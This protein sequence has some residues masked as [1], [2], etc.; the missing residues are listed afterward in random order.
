MKQATNKNYRPFIRKY[1]AY[2]TAL[3]V[4]FSYLKL[5][6]ASKIFGQKYYKKRIKALH[7]KNANRVKKTILELQGLFIKIGQLI[8]ILSNVL[9]DEFR[10][11]LESLQDK[12]PARPYDEVKKTIIREFGKTPQEL[13]TTF[14]KIPLAAA[15]IGQVHRATIDG[16]EVVVK[17]QHLNIPITSKADLVILANL[18][19]L[20]A[21]FMDVNGLDHL[22]EQVRLMVEDEL[23]YQ[24]EANSMNII[25]ENLREEEDLRVVIPEVFPDYSTQRVLTSAFCKGVNIGQIAQLDKWQID[26]DNLAKRIIELY[27]KMVLIDGFYQA[28]PH[29]GNILVNETGEIILL[30]YG[31]VARLTENTKNTIPE[32]I[33]AV[34]KDNTENIVKALKKMGFI[35][36]GREAELM[37]ENLI[38]IF[39]RFLL[40]EVEINGM[41]FKEIKL[42][43]GLGA[44][45]NII[46]Q[47]DIRDV[48]DTVQIPKDYVLLYR[49]AILLLGVSFQIAPTLNPVDVVKPY[50]EE[51]LV[52][53]KDSLKALVVNTLKG[54]LT[55]AL[56]LP[57]DLHRFLKDTSRGETEVKIKGIQPGFEMLWWLG[58]MIFFGSIT[59]LS[60]SFIWTSDIRFDFENLHGLYVALG[61]SAFFFLRAW[62]KGGKLRK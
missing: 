14:D 52:S 8:S 23:D 20:H 30:D 39:R 5:N 27:C 22:Y 13:F 49:A 4:A 31:A 29:P 51:N 25:R 43:S 34:L 15:S 3:V 24:R 55:T 16:K 26:R 33:E 53:R 54:Q 35:A 36:D 60:A 38:E 56:A 40:D 7:L 44:I 10:E 58:Q 18:V 28:D 50:I 32:L 6:L 48:S 62:R 1:K 2:K 11:P 19:K 42:K 17:V 57:Q 46:S 21:F 12:I 61:I 41:N 47:V 9:P 37:M 45:T 59:T